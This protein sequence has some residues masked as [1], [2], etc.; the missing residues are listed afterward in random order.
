MSQNRF[1]SISF[2]HENES[3]VSKTQGNSITFFY[4]C[5]L[6]TSCSPFNISLQKGKYLL[7]VWGAKGGDGLK[8]QGGNGGYSKGEL[9]VYDTQA[10]FLFIGGKGESKVTT[11]NTMGGYN[12]GGAG[13]LGPDSLE[14]GGGG[15][16]TDFR[17]TELM[18]SRII[19][20]GGGGGVGGLN[21]A[22]NDGG[23]GGGFSGISGLGSSGREKYA[24]SGA[25]NTTIGQ[26]GCAGEY[27]AKDG[28]VLNGGNGSSGDVTSGSGG[29]GGYFG[30]GGGHCAGAGG[31]SGYVSTA[32]R[33]RN[34]KAGN[35][36]FYDWNNQ[37][38]SGNQDNGYA[39]ITIL[40]SIIVGKIT[41]CSS[42]RMISYLFI[43]LSLS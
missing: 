4:P 5:K 42:Y 41:G 40:A 1:K 29:G 20:A 26:K 30:G 3:F 10:L 27:C 36:D 24:G 17:L 18:Y 14:H 7:E 35:Q 23:A 28:S 13:K 32:L 9:L 11:N 37:P 21:E 25:T 34:S 43:S 15:G 6:S 22:G 31:G 39:K 12:G 8:S 33:N 16:S 19:V 38:I 2:S